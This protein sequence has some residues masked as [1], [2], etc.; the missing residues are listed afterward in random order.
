MPR[1]S[2]H[3]ARQ[4]VVKRLQFRTG[5]ALYAEYRKASDGTHMYVVYS[6][7]EHWP[8]FV[9]HD[10]VW[11]EN[12]DRYSVTT[13]KHRSQAHPHCPTIGV[14]CEELRRFVSRGLEACPKI[15]RLVA[16]AVG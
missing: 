8:L 4:M 13:S 9:Y 2:S 7:G 10:G 5:G 6:Y 11:Y 1:L 12:I 14:T 16:V 15:E 3:A